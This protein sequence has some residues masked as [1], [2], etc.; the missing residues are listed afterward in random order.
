MDRDGYK[1]MAA[2]P[3]DAAA[4]IPFV[5]EQN[6]LHEISKIGGSSM[7]AQAIGLVLG[8]ITHGSLLTA[9]SAIFRGLNR[10]LFCTNDPAWYG[11]DRVHAYITNSKSDATLRNSQLVEA[12]PPTKSVFV[13]YVRLFDDRGSAPRFLNPDSGDRFAAYG[14]VANWEWVKAAPDAPNLPM[15]HTNRFAARIK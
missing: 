7:L 4:V 8:K 3:F 12:I 9:P 14:V 1:I 13:V 11:P 15:D 5:L 10:E 2:D 6:F